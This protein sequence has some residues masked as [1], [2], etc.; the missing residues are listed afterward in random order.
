MRL[1]WKACGFD[2]L[3]AIRNN[4]IEGRRLSGAHFKSPTSLL[5]QGYDSD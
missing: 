1:M 3:S 5:F 4:R 2:V